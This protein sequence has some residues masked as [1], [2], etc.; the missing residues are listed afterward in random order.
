MLGLASFRGGT[1]DFAAGVDE[2][3]GCLGL[4]SLCLF[5][6]SCVLLLRL[7]RVQNGT[8][9]IALVS[10]CALVVADGAFA[11]DETIRQE[12]LVGLNRAERLNRLVL[13]NVAILVELCK[14]V[15][16]N[17]SLV[18]GRCLVKDVKLDTEPVVDGL[19]EG[20]VLG[21]E[22]GRIYAFFEGLC[23]GCGTVL[24]L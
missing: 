24:I 2:P 17:L 21:A 14:D 12:A 19:V 8:A 10:S 16:D 9:S 1:V 11:L 5:G 18:Y 7:E 20:V 6:R 4:A 22:C 23:F 15:L 13:D 3:A